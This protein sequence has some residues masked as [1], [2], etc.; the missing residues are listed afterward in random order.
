V[1]SR[2]VI[3]YDALVAALRFLGAGS[4]MSGILPAAGGYRRVRRIGRPENIAVTRAA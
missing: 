1:F 2:I 4:V 3:E